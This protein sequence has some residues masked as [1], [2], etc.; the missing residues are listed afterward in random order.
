MISTLYTSSTYSHE[1]VF[2]SV[3]YS[4]LLSS[5]TF[6]VFYSSFCLFRSVFRP[7][8]LF[9]CCSDS[10]PKIMLL[11]ASPLL[12][13]VFVFSREE[14]KVFTTSTILTTVSFVYLTNLLYSYRPLPMIIFTLSLVLNLIASTLVALFSLNN[15][16]HILS[17]APDLILFSFA[18]V[19]FLL[20]VKTSKGFLGNK[21]SISLT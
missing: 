14:G 5:R 18:I 12:V 9:F 21:S 7:T 3:L 10:F 16:L 20:L 1:K 2:E 6:L 15:R 17:R 4:S 13:L 8:P 19:S 11:H